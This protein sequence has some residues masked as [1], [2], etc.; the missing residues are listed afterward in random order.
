MS[1]D[2]HT[3]RKTEDNEAR[4]AKRDAETQ[5]ALGT[6]ITVLAVPVIIGTLWADD[7]HQRVVNV[8]AGIVL[9][10]IGVGLLSYG[11]FKRSRLMR[12][13]SPDS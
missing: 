4:L 5:M 3:I 12:M 8:S 13:D 6:F 7:M 9:L 1:K 2:M 10:S 11:W